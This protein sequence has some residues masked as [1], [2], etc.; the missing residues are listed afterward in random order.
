M[1]FYNYNNYIFK[2]FLSPQV[3]FCQ[4]GVGRWNVRK[5]TRLTL[6]HMTVNKGEVLPKIYFIVES[7]LM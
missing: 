1:L 3:K 6:L 7:N 5:K 2:Y 4:S